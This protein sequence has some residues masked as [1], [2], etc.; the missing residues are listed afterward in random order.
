[1]RLLQPTP[2][3]ANF[4]HVSPQKK[5]PLTKWTKEATSDLHSIERLW[6]RFPEAIPAIVTG[7]DGGFTVIDLDVKNGKDAVTA[8]KALGLDL[9]DA[10]AVVE[11]ASGGIHLYFDYFEFASPVV[12][13]SRSQQRAS[14]EAASQVA[15]RVDRQNR[16]NCFM[17]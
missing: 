11:T 3:V 12:T 2:P 4:T 14:D 17:T 10:G 16:R 15:S 13:I 9:D 1:M 7:E 8:H 6:K 5:R